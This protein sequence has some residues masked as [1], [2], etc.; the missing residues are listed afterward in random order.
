MAKRK[1][2]ADPDPN[3]LVR[4]SAGVYRSEDERFE[5]RDGGTGWFITDGQ[6]ANDFGQ[7]LVVGPFA[8]LAAVRDALPEARRTT[9][10]PLPR[11]QP[12]EAADPGGDAARPKASRKPKDRTSVR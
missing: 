6:Q 4:V 9:I 1:A 12:A 3:R 2:P 11:P 8:T 7:P 10:R 5:V